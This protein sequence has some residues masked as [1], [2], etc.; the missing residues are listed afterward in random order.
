MCRDVEILVLNQ[1]LDKIH[2]EATFDEIYEC[3]E[4]FK[5]MFDDF[6]ELNLEVE[7]IRIDRL[8]DYIKFFNISKICE[9]D[10]FQNPQTFYKVLEE[11]LDS[12]QWKDIKIFLSNGN[13]LC[14]YKFC[15]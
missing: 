2:N 13:I 10:L 9:Y 15:D 7:E 11:Y 5:R 12:N 1:I 6:D 4:N 8:K 3:C 14:Y